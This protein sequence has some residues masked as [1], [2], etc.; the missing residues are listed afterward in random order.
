MGR[1]RRQ[2]NDGNAPGE[3]PVQSG[4]GNKPCSSPLSSGRDILL[5]F[6]SD[7]SSCY[8]GNPE[9][10]CQW[11]GRSEDIHTLSEL[12]EA[13]AD[14]EYVMRNLLLRSH[15]DIDMI[16][17]IDGSNGSAITT[18]RSPSGSGGG[19]V[20]FPL[21]GDEFK[22]EVI[23]AAET[24]KDV[25]IAENA[26]SASSIDGTSIMDDTE[27]AST[28]SV[29]ELHHLLSN[30]QSLAAEEMID[31][32]R[33]TVSAGT[34]AEDAERNGM[35]P[36]A[37]AYAA[38][39]VTFIRYQVVNE[40][41]ALDRWDVNVER[42]LDD[43]L[44]QNPHVPAL[45]LEQVVERPSE[46]P[47]PTDTSGKLW[48]DAF[49]YVGFEATAEC[50]SKVPEALDFLR[51]KAMGGGRKIPC[52]TV[53]EL[54]Q[55]DIA[56]DLDRTETT[57]TDSWGK[58][59]EEEGVDTIGNEDAYDN[60]Y[61]CVQRREYTVWFSAMRDDPTFS[62]L[63]GRWDDTAPLPHT[64]NVPLSIHADT[65]TA[66]V[67]QQQK[68]GIC[69]SRSFRSLASK[70]PF[71]LRFQL[72]RCILES[73]IPVQI[74]EEPKESSSAIGELREEAADLAKEMIAIF[75]DKIL[76]CFFSVDWTGCR[77]S[78]ALSEVFAFLIWD[79]LV[80]VIETIKEGRTIE[81]DESIPAAV[82]NEA[83]A[84]LQKAEDLWG[85]TESQLA[86][87]ECNG[88]YSRI[89]VLQ[90]RAMW[91]MAEY[92]CRFSVSGELIP[93]EFDLI[94]IDCLAP[95]ACR[96][97]LIAN[98]RRAM[99][100][101][102]WMVR[103][104]FIRVLIDLRE[105]F[106][107]SMVDWLA[108]DPV[109]C[110][111]R[112][113]FLF[114][115]GVS[116][117]TKCFLFAPTRSMTRDDFLRSLGCFS[118]V[119]PAKTG[120]RI[121]LAFSQTAPI[122]ELKP[123]QI[124]A[125]PEVIRN[126]YRFS[127]GCG[128]MG[129]GVARKAQQAFNLKRIPGAIQVRLGGV[130]GMLSLKIDFDHDSVGIRPSQVKFSSTSRILEVKKHS[131]AIKG[132][133]AWIF[134]DLIFILDQ[135]VPS[136]VFYKLATL[137]ACELALKYDD[138]CTGLRNMV[139]R[140][141]CTVEE[142]YW[143]N[144]VKNG[145]KLNG[146][147][148]SVSEIEKIKDEMKTPKEKVKLRCSVQIY[149][150]VMD[151]YGMLEEGQILVG[152]GAVTGSV[153]V[154]RSPALFPGDIQRAEAVRGRTEDARYMHLN[155]CVIF[156]SMGARPLADMLGGGDLDGDE[157]F[158]INDAAILDNA[159]MAGPHDYG[160]STA[161]T[162]RKIDIELC[163]PLEL[164]NALPPSLKEQLDVL[165][166]FLDAGNLVSKSKDAFDRIV[167]KF[168]VGSIAAQ[169]MAELHQYVLDARKHSFAISESKLVLMQNIINS[170]PSPAWKSKKGGRKSEQTSTSICAVL[171]EQWCVWIEKLD[172]LQR[173]LNP[174]LSGSADL[175]REEQANVRRNEVAGESMRK[176][177]QRKRSGEVDQWELKL[178]GDCFGPITGS[179]NRKCKLCDDVW[180]CSKKCESKHWK[181]CYKTRWASTDPACPLVAT[182]STPTESG[183]SSGGMLEPVKEKYVV[184]D[185]DI[186]FNDNDDL[187]RDILEGLVDIVFGRKTPS[188]FGLGDI[189][190]RCLRRVDLD[191]MAEMVL[192][193][194][195]CS[196]RKGL[197]ECKG[198]RG[199]VDTP[200]VY[201]VFAMKPRLQRGNIDLAT[202]LPV[203]SLN[204][205]LMWRDENGNTFP[206][207]PPFHRYRVANLSGTARVIESLK[208][209]VS[210]GTLVHHAMT[211][212]PNLIQPALDE[213]SEVFSLLDPSIALGLNTAQKQAVGTV[214]VKG[215][216]REGFFVVVGPPGTGKDRDVVQHGQRPWRRHGFG[217]IKC[218]SC[219]CCDE[220]DDERFFQ[221]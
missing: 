165:K 44:E 69:V 161:N 36:T 152:N 218:L 162:L 159:T 72:E 183:R 92:K 155:E 195:F 96:R 118:D 171:Y 109:L 62:E 146:S 65:C 48:D 63:L 206:L 172:I 66:A 40:H 57:G 169:E 114:D 181:H 16:D 93:V 101:S 167:D 95:G 160:S 23:R 105:P 145:R 130:K 22:A 21:K 42:A 55:S 173:K 52:N 199:A 207:D 59:E 53:V 184:V 38:V 18:C 11:L 149:Q 138:S 153:L 29:H 220:D 174:P 137:S 136:N 147:H 15:S 49:Q 117:N 202:Y 131:R 28:F 75:I 82:L 26:A 139:R 110:G 90:K 150:G 60:S 20:I 77:G 27:A 43:A 126:G 30:G 187:A 34:L 156:S 210:Q 51:E 197:K 188:C 129:L 140:M 6:L 154:A 125:M 205:L 91:P 176:L 89:Q 157:F 84:L 208:S 127:D 216:Y 128:V 211:R 168:G 78:I 88:K 209:E 31:T 94:N 122:A 46:L 120:D 132:Q 54:S 73:T 221:R 9:E 215:I 180:L 13:C 3:I 85:A 123:T 133:D 70:L 79:Y 189:D 164:R 214:V 182:T 193:E 178:C 4:G 213:D 144:V 113:E 170:C 200:H 61:R 179:D 166:R 33:A 186:T 190:W 115:K 111:R 64:V 81:F 12:A 100:Q 37:L 39:L 98:T 58:A 102:G 158:V 1:R 134:R 196:L 201:D 45:L 83:N 86:D 219:K 99:R 191:T 56:S 104:R 185:T 124:I 19:G 17:D 203:D 106:A 71:A 177:D 175:E 204:N 7:H 50:W 192:V 151:E 76:P 103:D 121:G 97:S 25:M 10:F 80:R 148:F 212:N 163:F 107:S 35:T 2:A 194:F 198:R 112:Y 41:Y 116:K 24:M 14:E 143:R 74:V 217:S 47:L 142:E 87:D 119:Q 68:Q 8:A 135:S 108:S 5:S 67:Q 32:Y 141:H